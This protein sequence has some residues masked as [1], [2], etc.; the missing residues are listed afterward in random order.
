MS[1]ELKP[2]FKFKAT[3]NNVHIRVAAFSM[4]TMNDYQNKNTATRF[5]K[6]KIQRGGNGRTAYYKN[7]YLFH[8]TTSF[9][10]KWILMLIRLC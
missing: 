6:N 7:I 3:F 10:A 5:R 2:I 1:H 4:L 8:L 9:S